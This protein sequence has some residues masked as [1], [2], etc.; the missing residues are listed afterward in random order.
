MKYMYVNQSSSTVTILN[1]DLASQGN[2][3]CVE[4]KQGALI[5]EVYKLF[6]G[7]YRIL[8]RFS[9]WNSWKKLT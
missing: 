7:I 9:S 8:H 5:D 2:Y 1:L 3:I 6:T 4:I